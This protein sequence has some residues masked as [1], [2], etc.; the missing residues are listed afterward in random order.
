MKT[1]KLVAHTNGGRDVNLSV[2]AENNQEAILQVMSDL[3]FGM[4]MPD[5]ST[6]VLVTANIATFT[7]LK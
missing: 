4:E 2:E 7:I 3:Y 1:V 5:G 6:E